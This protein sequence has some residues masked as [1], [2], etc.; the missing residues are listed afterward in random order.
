MNVEK[1]F[2][3]ETIHLKAFPT[4]CISPIKISDHPGAEQSYSRKP[5]DLS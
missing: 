1:Y 2:K 5:A 4:V 3:I